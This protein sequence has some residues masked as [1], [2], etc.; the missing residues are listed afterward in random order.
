MPHSE[1]LERL[2]RRWNGCPE[3]S[4]DPLAERPR[5]TGNPNREP[6]RAAAKARQTQA[7]G[8]R[9]AIRTGGGAQ[10]DARLKAAIA[11]HEAGKPAEAGLIRD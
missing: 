11:L 2:P 6:R 10:M 8:R 9:A 4:G 3:G 1:A 5:W 7:K